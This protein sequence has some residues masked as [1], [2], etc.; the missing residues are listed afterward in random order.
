MIYKIFYFIAS[1]NQ[2]QSINRDFYQE[3]LLYLNNQPQKN[4]SFNTL[5][6]FKEIPRLKYN[7]NQNVNK[8]S[9]KGSYNYCWNFLKINCNF[10][11]NLC[12]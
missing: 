9:E 3:L 5:K 7:F 1:F 2:N 11:C 8:T 10:E 12:I 4:S 6:W